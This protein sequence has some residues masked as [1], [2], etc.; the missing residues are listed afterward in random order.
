M[1]SPIEHFELKYISTLL[2]DNFII[3][4]L[5]IDNFV[6][7]YLSS[8]L[9]LIYIRL[10][11]P[12]KLAGS[13]IQQIFEGIYN[14]LI[15]M[16]LNQSKSWRN[17]KFF[18]LLY[19]I[20]ILIFF[21]N[22]FSLSPY[23]SSVSGHIM[24]TLSLSG[25]LFI[26]LIIIGLLNNRSKFFL[27]FYPS[28]VPIFLLFFLIIIEV[29]SF[30]IRPF[31]LAIRLFANMLAGHTSLN[32]FGAFAYFVSNNYW[33]LFLLSFVF[34][35]LITLLEVGVSI[36]QSYVFVVLL[37]IYISDITSVGH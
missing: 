31:S 15:D 33:Y 2:I 6:I 22:F 19:T 14:F 30:I 17:L 1:Y 32:I 9:I 34:C 4:S 24:I 26:G 7:F 23:T 21:L 27:L 20:F 29:L 25:S 18:P 35:V 37:A 8:I 28:N 16:L 11:A 10:F 5:S 3:S 36:I 12:I 13:F